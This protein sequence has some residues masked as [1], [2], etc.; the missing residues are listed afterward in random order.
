MVV[1]TRRIPSWEQKICER[2]FEEPRWCHV[3]R[4]C[5]QLGVIKCGNIYFKQTIAIQRAFKE[6]MMDKPLVKCTRQK[7]MRK[8]TTGDCMGIMHGQELRHFRIVS[9]CIHCNGNRGL[10]LQLYSYKSERWW[11]NWVT[12]EVIKWGFR[13][14]KNLVLKLYVFHIER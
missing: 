6:G 13:C 10:Q 3:I 12:R 8:F 2:A 11:M 7:P 1:I 5:L 4:F 9:A 14:I